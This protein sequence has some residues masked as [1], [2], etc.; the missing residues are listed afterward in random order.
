MVCDSTD[1][2]DRSL[3]PETIW[4]YTMVCNRF[5]RWRKT[6]EGKP[7]N[8]LDFSNLRW[9]RPDERQLGCSGSPT[10]D[11]SKKG[12]RNRCMDRSRRG[13][14][15]K[16]STLVDAAPNVSD[17]S[18]RKRRLCFSKARNKIQHIRHALGKTRRKSP[19]HAETHCH[20]DLATI[21]YVHG[22]AP[23]IREADSNSNQS[24]EDYFRI[25]PFNLVE[26]A[27]IAP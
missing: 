13:L 1:I 17:K 26:S 2:A 20:M 12:G 9:R 23:H 7:V 11:E 22:P 3:Q 19:R 10:C 21:K 5:N 15:T 25:L 14:S 16:I 27:L 24:Q 18:N 8:G 4:T 6:G